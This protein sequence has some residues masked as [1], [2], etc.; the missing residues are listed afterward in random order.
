MCAY[1]FVYFL[2][3]GFSKCVMMRRLN[4]LILGFVFI[5]ILKVYVTE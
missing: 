2:A 1:L 3:L 5:L 4:M